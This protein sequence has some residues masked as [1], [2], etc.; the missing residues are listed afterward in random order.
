MPLDITLLRRILSKDLMDVM[1][2]VGLIVFLVVMAVRI[3]APFMG[4][5]LWA[6]IL[7]VTLYPL[8][9][10]IAKRLGGRQGLAATL[11]VITGLLLI[12]GPIVMLGGSFADFLGELH[13]ALENKAITIPPPD[14]AVAEWPLIGTKLYALWSQA[15]RDLPGLLE[16]AQPQLVEASKHLLAFMATMA[17]GAFKF[18]GSMIVAGIMMAYGESGSAAMRRILCRLAGPQKGPRLHTL[19][20]ATIRSVAMGVIGVALIQAVLLGAGFMWA[21]IPAAG[22]LAFIV[23]I[24]GIA[25]VPA[26][27]LTVPVIVYIWWGGDASTTSN[28]LYTVYLLVAGM[29]DNFL[30]PLLLG[31]GVEAPMPIILL[32]ALGGMVVAGIIG[33]FTGSVLLAL[34]YQIFMEWVAEDESVDETVDGEQ[35]TEG[36]S[37]VAPAGD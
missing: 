32:G 33:L 10:R 7:A 5:M 21:A 30:K 23:L 4:L 26:S 28:I 2:R 35:A 25:Q 17:G 36:S 20:T 6:L 3:S 1:I 15:A 22:V 18:M 37:Q 24:I 31:R 9:L 11:L 34:G 27:I 16:K 14:A 19:S 13:T 12:G 8:H 29:A